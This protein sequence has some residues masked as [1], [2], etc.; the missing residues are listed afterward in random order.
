MLHD[1]DDSLV[2]C[3][4]IAGFDLLCIRADGTIMAAPDQAL[5]DTNSHVLGAAA[6]KV[7]GRLGIVVECSV[8]YALSPGG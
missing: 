1:Q 3:C 2:I 6:L 8:R 4:N 5:L 7:I